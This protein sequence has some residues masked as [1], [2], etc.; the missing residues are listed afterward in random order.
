MKKII[1]VSLILLSGCAYLGF[2]G[3]TVRNFPDIHEDALTDV[4]CLECHHPDNLYENAPE[5]PHPGFT[6]CLKCHNDQIE[7]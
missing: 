3:K 1:V 7:N 4:E 6:G 5:S 2:H